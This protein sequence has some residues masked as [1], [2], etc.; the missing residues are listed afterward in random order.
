MASPL[1]GSNE[2]SRGGGGGGEDEQAG[3]IGAKFKVKLLQKGRHKEVK[4]VARQWLTET[5]PL[6]ILYTSSREY[7]FNYVILTW[8]R[9]E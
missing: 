2:G 5:H 7:D 8:G 4:S 3:I 1:T 6:Y 9:G